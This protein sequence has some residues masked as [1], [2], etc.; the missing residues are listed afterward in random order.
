MQVVIYQ[1]LRLKNS[2]T[3]TSSSW[4]RF[5]NANFEHTVTVLVNEEQEHPHL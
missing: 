1:T 3:D 4:N 5:G 2:Y